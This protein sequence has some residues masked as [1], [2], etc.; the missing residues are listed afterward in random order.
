MGVRINVISDH[1]IRQWND[2]D[3]LIGHLS[4]TLPTL[5][6]IDAYWVRTGEKND[7][8]RC[9]QASRPSD[10]FRSVKLEGPGSVWLTLTP[11][12]AMIHTGGRWRGFMEIPELRQVHLSA[13]RDILGCL[14]ASF[15]AYFPD[16]D[17]VWGL[18]YEDRPASQVEE[19]LVPHFGRPSTNVDNP[20]R[21]DIQKRPS[22]WFREDLAAALRAEAANSPA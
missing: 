21:S 15:A 12:I 18:F 22:V 8:L 6:K 20:D 3:W 9:W 16:F 10:S 4:K 14:R 11:K 13:F 19:L 5:E 7:R 2:V 1:Q 17:D